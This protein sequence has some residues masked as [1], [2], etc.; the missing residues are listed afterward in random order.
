MTSFARESKPAKM[1]GQPRRRSEKGAGLLVQ[2]ICEDFADLFFP[3]N[4]LIWSRI[5]VPERRGSH[6]GKECV[7]RLQEMNEQAAL[8]ARSGPDQ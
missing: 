3:G 8:A 4:P 1:A 6:V 2:R 7:I 5:V